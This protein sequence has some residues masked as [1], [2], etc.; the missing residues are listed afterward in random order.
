MF[1]LCGVVTV[2]SK[3]REFLR[4]F[5][6]SGRICGSPWE[7][8]SVETV[9]GLVREVWKDEL[10]ARWGIVAID[11]RI[12]E[13]CRAGVLSIHE[14]DFPQSVSDQSTLLKAGGRAYCLVAIRH[15]VAASLK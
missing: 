7:P 6:G 9:R 13:L 4:L 14:H 1:L 15:E 5:T 10:D 8:L 11:Q 2:D 12:L 3:T